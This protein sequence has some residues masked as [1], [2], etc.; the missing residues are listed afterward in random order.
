[1][2]VNFALAH[3][4]RAVEVDPRSGDGATPPQIR[5]VKKGK[6]PTGPYGHPLAARAPRRA[7]R[8]AG[9]AADRIFFHQADGPRLSELVGEEIERFNDDLYD[10]YARL[11]NR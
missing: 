1:V 11:L 5:D 7:E 6:Q 8:P 2:V 3:L 10:E 4:R 9:R